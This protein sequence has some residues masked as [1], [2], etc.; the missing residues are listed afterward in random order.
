MHVVTAKSLKNLELGR[1]KGTNHLE[2]IPKSKESNRKRSIAHKKFWR[3]H[4]EKLA[5]RGKKI[6]GEN[7][8]RWSGGTTRLN[9]SIR[10]MNENRKWSQAVRARDGVCTDCG[11]TENLEADHIVPLATLLKVH[12]ITNNDEA[13][14]C[15][16]LWD[17]NN[18]ITLCRSCHCKKDGRK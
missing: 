1:E 13:R 9:K 2:G 4:P 10:G 12:K 11:T 5:E 15:K 17:I 18:G 8:Y 7:H 16:E 14:E 6:R 3:E